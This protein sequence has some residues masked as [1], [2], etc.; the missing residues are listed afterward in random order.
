MR[1]IGFD[2]P[3]YNIVRCVISFQGFE[4]IGMASCGERPGL[5]A[6]DLRSA[7]AS[8]TGINE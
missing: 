1:V 3:A 6:K 7:I 2:V 5:N 8:V 4:D